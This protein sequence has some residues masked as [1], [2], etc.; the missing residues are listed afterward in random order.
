MEIT[1][2]SKSLEFERA[3]RNISAYFM[4][5]QRILMLDAKHNVIMMK[6][7]LLVPVT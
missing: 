6:I 2:L 7:A 1:R 5:L 3:C 4:K